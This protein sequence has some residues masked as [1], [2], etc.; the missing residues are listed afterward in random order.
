[1]NP[2]KTPLAAW[3][4]KPPPLT[5]QQRLQEIEELLRK[6]GGY[7]ELMCRQGGLAGASPEG[8]DLAVA[9]FYDRM[10]TLERELGRIC[11][12]FRPE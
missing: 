1:V 10:A 7:A 5:T 8:R 9:D 2:Y 3:A 6:L 11:D 4:S 12:G